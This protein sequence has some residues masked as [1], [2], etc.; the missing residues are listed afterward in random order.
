MLLE[1]IKN[2][3]WINEPKNVEFIEKGLLISTKHQTDFWQNNAFNISKDDGHFFACIKEG[4][5]VIST[6]WFFEMTIES[7][8]C[9]ILVK[10]DPKNWIKVG[11]LPTADNKIQIG[12]VVASGGICDWS[13]NDLDNNLNSLYFTIKRRGTNFIVY[14]S[15]DGTNYSQIRLINH[16][17]I[18]QVIDVGAYA[19]S[20]KDECF[21]CVLEEIEVK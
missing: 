6:K 17:H 4:D 19:C 1:N 7:A 20:P 21:D 14:Y 11:L 3:N 2:F 8:Q 10:S 9:G 12:T 16:P 13:I 15:M 5:F 18:R